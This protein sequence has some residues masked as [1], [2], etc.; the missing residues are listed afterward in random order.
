MD[1]LILTNYA[2][3]WPYVPELV[4]ELRAREVRVDILDISDLQLL[5][6][7]RSPR[8]LALPAFKFMGGFPLLRLIHRY[9]ALR[10]FARSLD[11]QYD[12]LNVHSVSPLFVVLRRCFKR[13]ADRTIISVWGSD[14]YRVSDRVRNWE[15]GLYATAA[16]IT[17]INPQTRH[18]FVSYFRD[19][20]GKSVVVKFGLGSLEVIN[21]ISARESK[22]ES[23]RKLGIP[24]GAFVITCGYN[25]HPAQQHQKI[26]ESII[27]VKHD[28][29]DNVFLVFPMT[30]PDNL[31]YVGRIDLMLRECGIEYMVFDSMMSSED[32]ARIRL[33][34]DVAV[35]MQSTDQLSAS[36]QEH[37][38][39]GSVV[40]VAEWLPYAIYRE[41]GIIYFAVSDF[42]MLSEQ[43]IGCCDRY[44]ELHQCCLDNREK[45]LDYASWE[46]NIGS[47]LALYDGCSSALGHIR[48]SEGA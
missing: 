39:T 9:F 1:I 23:R 13:M 46:N 3:A 29:P 18:D 32:V 31:D 38:F 6:A 24:A 30:Y 45:V 42:G 48:V 33:S 8:S 21:N 26:L 15:R 10:S 37:L 36:I 17:F 4:N 19:F 5:C 20:S 2:G 14:F 44:D 7:D 47:W 25:A 12:V 27:S 40:I 28:L 34:T 22:G 35:N 11:R 41:L 43:L 16:A